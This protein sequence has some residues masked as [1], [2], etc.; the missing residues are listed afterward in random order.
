MNTEY[1]KSNMGRLTAIHKHKATR[2]KNKRTTPP[3][4]K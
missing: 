3:Y 4:E 1:G 2:V